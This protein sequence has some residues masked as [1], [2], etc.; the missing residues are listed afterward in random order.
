[1]NKHTKTRTPIGE[2]PKGTIVEW[3]DEFDAAGLVYTHSPTVVIPKDPEAPVTFEGSLDGKTFAVIRDKDNE[4]VRVTK[5]GCYRL[6]VAVC[7]LR[8]VSQ[9]P[10]YVQTFIQG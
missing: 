4:A 9:K 6:P 5:A 10:C 7:F 2:Y 1:M 8:P 3:N